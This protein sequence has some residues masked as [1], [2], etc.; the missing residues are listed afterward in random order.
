MLQCNMAVAKREKEY[1]PGYLAS[2]KKAKFVKQFRSVQKTNRGLRQFKKFQYRSSSP[3]AR[4]LSAFGRFQAQNRTGFQRGNSGGR[5][6]PSGSYD[7]RYAAYGGVYGFRKV[8]AQQLREARLQ[9][10]RNATINPQQQAILARAEAQR[11]AAL[12]NPE[13][14]IIP[15]TSGKVPLRSIHQEIE[16]A[17]NIFP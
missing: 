3:V 4:G 11:R 2:R 15:D 6:R 1:Y 8:Q 17:A 14:Q 13:N 7:P 9:A 10:I 5:G 12:T 16:D